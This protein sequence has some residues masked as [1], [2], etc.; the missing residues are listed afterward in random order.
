M[1]D[2]KMA[3][4]ADIYT[5]FQGLQ[6][7]Q[8]KN[9]N[10]PE[11][12]KK[13]V[14]QQFESLLVQMLLKSMR[15]TNKALSSDLL[16]SDQSAFYEDLFDKQL[17]LVLS[18]SGMGIAK[19]IETYLD[20]QQS[21]RQQSSTSTNTMDSST[22][23]NSVNRA[24]SVIPAKAGI[25]PQA[26]SNISSAS[27]LRLRGADKLYPEHKSESVQSGQS[28][29]TFESTDDFVKTLWDSAK[30]AAHIIGVDP[31]LLLAQAALE[32]N[33]GKNIISHENGE[34]THNLFNI[35][36]DKSWSEK[37]ASLDTIEQ[38][39]NVLVKEKSR[40]RAYNSYLASFID[41][42]RFLQ[43][44]ARYSEA[45]QNVS[46]PGKFVQSLQNANYATD[47]L[48]SEKVMDIFSSHKFNSLFEHLT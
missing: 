4:D 29:S 22:S 7:L 1:L 46:D 10:Q 18:K 12:A 14:A 20:R 17:A 8:Y 30:T 24:N 42:T 11:L 13:E 32:T 31:K 3:Y 9:K 26:V 45:L 39:D 2:T 27:D 44:N 41:Y 48:Y 5:N 43:Q 40:F 38:K 25:H 19:T 33:W 36:A 15:D 35:K 34:S 37:S 16:Q 23:V 47:S 28:L 21:S 6:S